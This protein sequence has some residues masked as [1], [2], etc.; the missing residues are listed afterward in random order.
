MANFLFYLKLN[1]FVAY[2]TGASFN[3]DKHTKWISTNEKI[4]SKIKIH[5]LLGV[6]LAVAVV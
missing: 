1:A 5:F 4:Q 2:S 6:V 3:T